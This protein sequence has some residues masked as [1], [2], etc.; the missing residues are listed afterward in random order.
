M[1]CP[2]FAAETAFT[3]TGASLISY[4]VHHLRY[5]GQ[6]AYEAQSADTDDHTM[7][8]RQ[9]IPFGTSD[10]LEDAEGDNIANLQLIE[11][12]LAPRFMTTISPGAAGCS[13]EID[14]QRSCFRTAESSPSPTTFSVCVSAS[15]PIG[16][17][18][19][20]TFPC[21]PCSPRKLLKSNRTTPR[22]MAL[23]ATLNAGQCQSPT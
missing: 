9:G 16:R 15:G 13:V 8:E 20:G 6:V 4:H 17:A 23:S 7:E 3:S 2:P 5:Q 10:V 14:L 11:V 1:I 12:G 19:Q 18:D 22:V 21:S